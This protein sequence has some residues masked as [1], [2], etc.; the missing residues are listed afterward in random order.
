M[1]SCFGKDL[2]APR[3]VIL[4]RFRFLCLILILMVGATSVQAAIYSWKDENGKTHFTDNPSKIPHKYRK[5]KGLK[6]HRELSPSQRVTPDIEEKKLEEISGE[7]VDPDKKADSKKYEIPMKEENGQYRIDVRFNGMLLEDM[8]VDTG[9]NMTVL[10]ISFFKQLGLQFKNTPFVPMGTAGGTVLTPISLMKK[11]EIGGAEV[12]NIPVFL[13]VN[14]KGLLGT[15]VLN[16]FKWSFDRENKLL[17]LEPL[18][19]PGEPL[20]DGK[21]GKWWR[22]KFDGYAEAIKYYEAYYKK[23]EKEE[24]Y[25]FQESTGRTFHLENFRRGINLFRKLQQNL[26]R[27][28]RQFRVPMKYRSF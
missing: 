6:R 26:D 14:V 24:K 17:I 16:E 11:V 20:W 1:F 5:K 7:S 15:D 23:L 21:N 18:E 2:P 27:R 28:A 10:H 9:A 12:K 19:F 4:K 3:Y 13:S 22:K 8:M 25:A